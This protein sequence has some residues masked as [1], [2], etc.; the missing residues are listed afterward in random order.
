MKRNREKAEIMV[1]SKQRE[2][3][4]KDKKNEIERNQ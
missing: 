1:I 4:D 3:K 2:C